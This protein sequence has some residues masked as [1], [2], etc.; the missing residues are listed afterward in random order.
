MSTGL[1]CYF[2][3]Y[4]SGRWYYVLETGMG[5]KSAWDWSEYADATGP[6]PTEEAA[7]GHL[8]KN[9]A[10]PGGSNTYRYEGKWP[11]DEVEAKLIREAFDPI[12]LR[13]RSS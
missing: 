12:T 4:E 8:H 11:L 2:K 6:F 7:E 10:N 5:P 1:N 9:N 13:R 3:E